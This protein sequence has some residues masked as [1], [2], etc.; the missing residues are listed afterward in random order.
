VTCR[1][2]YK[3]ICQVKRCDLCDVPP[4]GRIWTLEGSRSDH[5]S[6]ASFIIFNDRR[7]F[8]EA[9]IRDHCAVLWWELFV[10]H[11]S[12]AG[13]IGAIPGVVLILRRRLAVRDTAWMLADFSFFASVPFARSRLHRARE[14]RAIA[15]ADNSPPIIYCLSSN[16]STECVARLP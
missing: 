6:H 12:S 8:S 5:R 10:C 9:F 7:A 3:K 1:A 11:R 15:L 13:R 14:K 16:N 4:S 2:E